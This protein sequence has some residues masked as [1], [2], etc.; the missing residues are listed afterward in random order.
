MKNI[1]F[2]CSL[3]SH[4]DLGGN[5]TMQE[6]ELIGI[7]SEFRRMMEVKIALYGVM[8]KIISNP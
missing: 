8:G 3:W 4:I 6:G 1:C 2:L 5:A 7:V